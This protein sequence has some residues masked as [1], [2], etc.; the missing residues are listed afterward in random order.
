[1]NSQKT[2]QKIANIAYI[3]TKVLMVICFV[4]AGILAGSAVITMAMSA[5]EM[6]VEVLTPTLNELEIEY[7]IFQFGIVSIAEAL[8]LVAEGIV[9]M[10]AKRYFKG[11]VDDGTPF[12]HRGADELKYLGIRLLAWPFGAMLVSSIICAIAGVDLGADTSVDVGLGVSCILL[13]FV[14]HHGADLK[15]KADRAEKTEKSN[16]DSFEIHN[17]FD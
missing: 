5:S 10:Y 17:L 9:F 1:M 6:V 3:V 16:D 11:I 8:I 14:F 12:T 13:S 15:E 7:T 4:C 2:V